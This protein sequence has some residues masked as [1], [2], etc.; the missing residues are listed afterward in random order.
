MGQTGPPQIR[1]SMTTAC[2]VEYNQRPPGTTDATTV[3]ERTSDERRD[4]RYSASV[5]RAASRKSPPASHSFHADDYGGG[6]GSPDLVPFGC[7][8]DGRDI[9]PRH[10][11][12]PGKSERARRRPLRPFE[13]TRRAGAVRGA[14]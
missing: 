2:T 10:E 14:G 5:H 11:V 8:A 13:R 9:F 6:V 12:R 3:T 7:G 4:T 1:P